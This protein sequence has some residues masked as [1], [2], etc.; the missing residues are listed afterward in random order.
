MS[1]DSKFA[2]FIPWALIHCAYNRLFL[3]TGNFV[4]PSQ[5]FPKGRQSGRLFS[6]K[7]EFLCVKIEHA[8]ATLLKFKFYV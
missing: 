6:E 4:S 1:R 2:Y 8:K 7:Y 3:C 5:M